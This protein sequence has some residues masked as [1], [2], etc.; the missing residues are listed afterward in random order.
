MKFFFY[1]PLDQFDLYFI[2]NIN[3]QPFFSIFLQ[4]IFIKFNISNL[5]FLNLSVYLLILISFFYLIICSFN[6]KIKNCKKN[7]NLNKKKLFLL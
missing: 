6:L 2:N 7:E 4:D 3:Y 1:Q 5:M